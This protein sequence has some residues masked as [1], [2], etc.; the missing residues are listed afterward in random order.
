G[1][2]HASLRKTSSRPDGGPDAVSLCRRSHA[3]GSLPAG[4]GREQA[5]AAMPAAASAER[6]AGARHQRAGVGPREKVKAVSVAPEPRAYASY[7]DVDA[8]IKGLF[9]RRL[10]TQ[11]ATWAI[12]TAR[13]TGCVIAAMR[14]CSARLVLRAA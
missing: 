4:I 7:P 6:A 5:P 10:L 13:I 9:Q 2:L 8:A 12:R 3:N 14:S 1:G 11:A